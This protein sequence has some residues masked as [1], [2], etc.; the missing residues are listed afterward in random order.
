MLTNLDLGLS[1]LKI[2][3]SRR[4]HSKALLIDFLI[5]FVPSYDLSKRKSSQVI[6]SQHSKCAKGNSERQFS[7]VVSYTCIAS[8]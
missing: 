2:R 6:L 1:N 4:I 3:R 5:V 7:H 8:L